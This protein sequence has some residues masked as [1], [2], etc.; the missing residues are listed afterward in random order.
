LVHFET[1][2]KP[3]NSIRDILFRIPFSKSVMFYQ[4]PQCDRWTIH[5]ASLTA[6]NEGS[7]NE[8]V[9]NFSSQ[10]GRDVCSDLRRVQ[11]LDKSNHGQNQ[12]NQATNEMVGNLFLF[13]L[14]SCEQQRKQ[15]SESSKFEPGA[16]MQIQGSANPKWQSPSFSRM[17]QDR[18]PI[19]ELY[20]R[21]RYHLGF[22]VSLDGIYSYTIGA[23]FKSTQ[24]R[25]GRSQKKGV[26]YSGWI[27]FRFLQSTIPSLSTTKFR[28][29]RS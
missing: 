16:R 4:D 2:G 9:V 20:L 15:G 10:L 12:R 26:L 3:Q 1:G 22:E 23:H 21:S 29:R 13:P 27:Y 5:T 17:P 14:Y 8:S 7:E 24:L 28:W 19:C 11:G 18:L 6:G 25:N